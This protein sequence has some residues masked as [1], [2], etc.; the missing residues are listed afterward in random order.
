MLSPTIAAEA[1]TI[2]STRTSSSSC[3]ARKPA[4]ITML[5]P[6]MKKP[7]NAWHS[8]ITMRNTIT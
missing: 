4:T 6:G 5:S 3:P 2:M 7:R 8:S 1:T